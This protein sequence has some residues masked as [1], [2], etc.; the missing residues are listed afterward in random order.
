MDNY[1]STQQGWQCPICK[2]VYSP[3]TMMCCYC[4]GNTVISTGRTVDTGVIDIDWPKHESA[5]TP[6]YKPQYDDFT[7][8]STGYATYIAEDMRTCNNCKHNAGLPRNNGT[9]EYNG[10]CKNCIAKDKWEQKDGEE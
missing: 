8:I 4:G 6:I 10:A 2:R 9:M 7:S 1:N 5:T 3:Y